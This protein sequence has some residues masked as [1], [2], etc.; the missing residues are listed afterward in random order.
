MLVS[1]PRSVLLQ[2]AVIP[3]AVSGVCRHTL[4]VVGIGQLPAATIDQ[5]QANRLTGAPTLFVLYDASSLSRS[6][7]MAIGS[8]DEATQFRSGLMTHQT[9][10]K[11]KEDRPLLSG[12]ITLG[13]KRMFLGTGR[14]PCD[15]KSS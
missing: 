5:H 9:W 11:P 13:D 6:S 4:D 10:R 14:A 8:L 1:A 7:S 12:E 15:G 2:G 3:D